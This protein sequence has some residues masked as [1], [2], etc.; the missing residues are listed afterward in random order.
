MSAARNI[1]LYP[2]YAF[3]KNLMFWQ[4]VWFLYL[5]GLVTAAGAIALYA[6]LELS[7][8]L[9][10]VP[11]GYLSDRVGRRRTLLLAAVAGALGALLLYLGTGYAILLAGMVL[12]GAGGAFAS[13]TDSALLYESLRAEGRQDDVAREELRAW[14]MSFAALAVSAVTGGLFAQVSPAL[15]FLATALAHG[16]QLAITWQFR[17]PHSVPQVS[18]AQRFGEMR[19]TLR[20]P[21]L[22][23]LLALMVGMYILG[24]IPFVFGQPFIAAALDGVGLGTEAPLVS[25]LVT[26]LMMAVS[27]AGTWLAL[28]A[29]RALGLPRL[30]LVAFA[31]HVA[32]TAVLAVSQTAFA[33]LFLVLRKLP[34]ALARAFIT[35]RIQPLLADEV[36]ATFLSFVSLVA[37][38][39]FAGSLFLAAGGAQGAD[40]MTFAALARVL[41]AY[42]LLG[43]ALWLALWWTARRLPLEDQA[44]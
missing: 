15:P 24:H 9:L 35:A 3:A 29:R 4:A 19:A 26:A 1:R 12:L 44:P 16:A 10:E 18:E 27:V 43:L 33:I 20:H 42:A 5:E 13:G 14:R 28:P 21:V 36:R 39:V 6:A 38:L 2:W 32:L 7:I 40:T 22:L 11:S 41:G 8:T 30:L 31:A 23:W 34:D 37:R 25:G 17:L